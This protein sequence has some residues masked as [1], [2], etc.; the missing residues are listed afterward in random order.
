[1]FNSWD[2]L[3]VALA[4]FWVRRWFKHGKM[5]GWNLFFGEFQLCAAA[6]LFWLSFRCRTSVLLFFNFHSV[7]TWL[8]CCLLLP[9]GSIVASRTT[10][11]KK[12][13]KLWK[14]ISTLLHRSY[15]SSRLCISGLELLALFFTKVAI[16]P[17]QM[18]SIQ[19]IRKKKNGKDSQLPNG[20]PA[21]DN[22]RKGKIQKI[23]L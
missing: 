12:I 8:Q 19:R 13:W 2:V 5:L 11:K 20:F 23:F 9:P 18:S 16:P 7:G 4:L 15:L 10:G 22:F 3:D 1:M 17:R 21:R 14:K 6:S